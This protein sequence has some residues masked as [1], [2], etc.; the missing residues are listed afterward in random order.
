MKLVTRKLT[1]FQPKLKTRFGLGFKFGFNSK[2]NSN[3]SSN[4]NLNPSSKTNPNF[5][6]KTKHQA[7]QALRLGLIL[8]SLT[9]ITF[10][11]PILKKTF[12][13]QTA[14]ADTITKTW[15]L[16]QT[17]TDYDYN[18]YEIEQT[19]TGAKLKQLPSSFTL[20]ADEDS[21]FEDW[22]ANIV[23][24]G[25]EAAIIDDPSAGGNGKVYSATG[26]INFTS[27]FLIPINPDF[28]IPTN[29]NLNQW[30]LEKLFVHFGLIHTRTITDQVCHIVTI[31][32]LLATQL[33]LPT[34]TIRLSPLNRC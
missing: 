2:L 20:T 11:T 17:T 34:I 23:A 15:Q 13:P 27:K 25:G 3:P 21:I 5:K 4:P 14:S 1:K 24:S 29:A 16:D 9:L 22:N 19:T 30:A 32:M 33:L 8:T 6:I 18:T 7:Y 31:T 12:Q 28:N 26:H 10:L